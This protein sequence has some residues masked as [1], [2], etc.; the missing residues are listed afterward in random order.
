MYHGQVM[1]EQ[2]RIPQLIQT[3]QLLEIR[4]L[5]EVGEGDS[6]TIHEPAATTDREENVKTSSNSFL[7]GLLNA[8]V[9]A[10][11]RSSSVVSDSLSN[12][13]PIPSP[14][15]KRQRNSVG[16]PRPVP[17]L[18]SILSQQVTV[19]KTP[20][21]DLTKVMGS[22]T[23]TLSAL[24]SK[25]QASNTSSS[26]G[27]SIS[28]SNKSLLP[29]SL[30]H[31][32]GGLSSA[33]A[34]SSA[35]ASNGGDN[36]ATNS[37]FEDI[38]DKDD[39]PE[40]SYGDMEN[41]SCQGLE[42][43]PDTVVEIKEEPL[44]EFEDFGEDHSSNRGGGRG[45][46]TDDDEDDDSESETEL[47]GMS[48]SSRGEAYSLPLLAQH[49]AAPNLLSASAKLR[50]AASQARTVSSGENPSISQVVLSPSTPPDMG[51]A[52]FFHLIQGFN[53]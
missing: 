31:L 25:A 45:A 36:S 23:K 13:S 53:F 50:A 24:V 14:V 12:S 38:N 6:S 8:G 5:C 49:L 18:Q 29:S 52:F 39:R 51:T 17:M 15:A 35:G 9:S 30:S 44:M 1:I 27:L 2:D 32:L 48:D 41:S 3:A 7:A 34:S 43:V 20:T 19:P 37:S 22:S 4:G 40:S 26:S 46:R 28:C 21:F 11:K 42:L 33:I 47:R 10:T 16:P